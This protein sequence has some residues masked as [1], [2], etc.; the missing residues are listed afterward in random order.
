MPADPDQKEDVELP[1]ATGPLERDSGD[2]GSFFTAVET[3]VEPP[4]VSS[5]VLM[6]KRG[7]LLGKGAPQHTA[8]ELAPIAPPA[9]SDSESPARSSASRRPRPKYPGPDHDE[10][11]LP[12]ERWNI[13]N[14]YCLGVCL[15]AVAVALEWTEVSG[16]LSDWAQ[17][18]SCSGCP[19]HYSCD[20]GLPPTHS[21]TANGSATWRRA[22]A[23]DDADDEDGEWIECPSSLAG[24]MIW[25][26]T[27]GAVAFNTVLSYGAGRLHLRNPTVWKVNYTRKISH[28][29]MFMMQIAVRFVAVGEEH[30]IETVSTLI[31]TST[32]Y[33]MLYHA[34]L[35][36]PVRRRFRWA[37]VVFASLDRP[38][39][40]PYTLRWLTTQNIAYYAVFTPLMYCLIAVDRFELFLIPTLV[41]GLGDGLAE[42]V[43]IRWG[44][45]KYKTR[46]IW[47]DDKCCAGEFTRSLEGSACVFVATVIA[48]AIMTYEFS[49]T[50]LVA[51][52]ASLPISMTL[53]EAYA[54][55]TWDTPFLFGIGGLGVFLIAVLV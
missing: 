19:R 51:A 45:H 18:E 11:L 21:P 30:H 50:Q 48:I 27:V 16:E 17:R 26:G 55:H 2:E 32:L 31:V 44:R 6:A 41:V 53:A 47:Y 37:R 20:G 33:M 52:Y 9:G 15:L 10:P 29:T 25:L 34:V 13:A 5:P 23:A 54:P 35:L 7:S 49:G 12:H 8:A 40:R 36:K 39:D 28:F 42:P 1:D 14:G 24:W 4:P 46:A 43:G 3:V 22:G 38:E